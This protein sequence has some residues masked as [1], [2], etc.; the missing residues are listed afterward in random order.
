MIHSSHPT[1]PDRATS[2]VRGGTRRAEA[3]VRTLDHITQRPLIVLG[4]LVAAFVLWVAADARAPKP[5]AVPAPPQGLEPPMTAELSRMRTVGAALRGVQEGMSRAEVEAILGR[6]SPRDIRPVER[7]NGRVVYRTHYLA[8]LAG[9]LPFAPH[10]D[11]YCEAILEYD[12]AAPGHPL[13]RIL[14]V[15]R[16]VPG[17]QVSADVA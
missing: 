7:A 4:V 15:P 3:K 1:A 6:P 9:P 14:A 16:A 12:A 5:K 11:G 17:A 10:V 13:L 8:F 2:D